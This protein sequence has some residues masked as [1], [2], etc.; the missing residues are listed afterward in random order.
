MFV[1]ETWEDGGRCV[2]LSD[3]YFSISALEMILVFAVTLSHPTNDPRYLLPLSNSGPRT[4]RWLSHH[5]KRYPSPYSSIFLAW[6]EE[7]IRKM[8]ERK[9]K[10]VCIAHY[11]PAQQQ[12]AA[13]HH[14]GTSVL[15]GGVSQYRSAQMRQA[16]TWHASTSHS[17]GPI[18]GPSV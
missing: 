2:V 13:V 9:P 10:F 3:D 5:P 17:G 7:C 18:S 8:A 1:F 6:P 14:T 15:A 4:Q 11:K 16:G 12:C